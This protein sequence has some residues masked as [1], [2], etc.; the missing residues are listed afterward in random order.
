[1]QRLP[2]YSILDTSSSMR[3][4]PIEAVN[5][6]IRVMG[7]A[8]RQDPHA[9]DSD[10]SINSD[11]LFGQPGCPHYNAR[12]DMAACS[13]GKVLCVEDDGEKTCQWRSRHGQYGS[14][15]VGQGFNMGWGRG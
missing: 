10:Q 15:E 14:S 1:M 3:G 4:E 6:G 5:T 13:C 2:V 11:N 12:F 7:C 8:L 9:A